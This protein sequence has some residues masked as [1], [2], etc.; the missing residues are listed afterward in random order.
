MVPKGLDQWLPLLAFPS[1]NL[2]TTELSKDHYLSRLSRHLQTRAE[3]MYPDP[4]QRMDLWGLGQPYLTRYDRDW[5]DEVE[6]GSVV[7]S[8]MGIDLVE[9]FLLRLLDNPVQ[10]RPLTEREVEEVRESQLEELLMIL[11]QTADMEER[12]MLE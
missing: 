4:E 2:G 12:G 5:E 6:P 9:S 8:L 7:R 1:V 10:M 11:L 3:Q